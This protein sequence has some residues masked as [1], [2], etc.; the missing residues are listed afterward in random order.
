MADDGPEAAS[1]AARERLGSQ[2]ELLAEMKVLRRQARAARHAYWFPLVLFGLLACA[3]VPFYVQQVPR[4]SGVFAIRSGGPTLPF[5]GSYSGFLPPRYLPYYWIAALLGGLLATQL[6]YRWHARRVGLATPARAYLIT[7]VV[8]TV[9]AI[10]LPLL[11]VAK[12][13]P[14]WRWLNGLRVL[15]PGDLVLRGTFPFLII[16]VGLLALAWSERSRA[17]TVIAVVYTGA[18]LLASLYDVSN[19][20]YR[21]GWNT[22]IADESLPNV[23][24]PAAVLLLA[25]A[26]TLAA[27]RLHRTTA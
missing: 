24:L 4:A 5:F 6:W 27:R 22:S 13:P 10:V 15:W 14:S 21:V 25:G 7:T 16:A 8:L 9:A 26:G 1:E 20:L 12:Y 23:L 11:S 2:A 19:L 3:S 17:L 18:A